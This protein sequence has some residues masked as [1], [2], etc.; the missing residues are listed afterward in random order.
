M[1]KTLH[2]FIMI[3]DSAF[4]YIKSHEHSKTAGVL[5]KFLQVLNQVSPWY[6][7]VLLPGTCWFRLPLL[8]QFAEPQEIFGL[9]P[10]SECWDAEMSPSLLQV[11]VSLCV[12]AQP[13]GL[14]FA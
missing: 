10:I 3:G 8:V 1:I 11:E 12:G 4:V 6:M 2:C 13:F 5:P 14:A 9:V 7:I